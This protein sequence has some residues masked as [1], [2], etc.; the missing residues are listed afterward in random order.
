MFPP[1]GVSWLA[2]VAP[3][4]FYLALPAPS[5]GRAAAFG[6]TVGTGMAAAV[7]APWLWPT[8]R[9]VIAAPAL[10]RAA[11]LLVVLQVVGGL[12]FAALAL[13]A[14]AAGAVAPVARVLLLAAAWTGLEYV[15]AHVPFGTPWA[16]LGAA[17]ADAPLVAQI[18]DLGGVYAV[19]F[20]AALPSA[21]L[22]VAVAVAERGG[23]ARR[24]LVPA[25]AMAALILAAVLAYGRWRLADVT[26]AMRAAPTVRM[27]LVHTDLPSLPHPGPGETRRSLERHLALSPAADPSVD[28]VVWPE[29]AVPALLADD[30]GL[31]DAIRARG[32]AMPYLVGAP[33]IV[34]SGG[35]ATLRASLFL[36]DGDGIRASYDKRELLP[37]VETL[38]STWLPLAPERLGFSPGEGRPVLETNGFTIGPLICYEAIFPERGRAAVR[39]GAAVLLNVSND[40]WLPP[41]ATAQHFLFARLRA[42]EVRRTL[43]RVANRGV[44]AVVDADGRARLV[45]DGTEAGAAIATI[46]RLA[47]LTVYAR[48]GDAFAWLCLAYVVA[49]LSREA[50]RTA[51][52][53]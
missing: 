5:R 46:P 14:H 11:L 7:V 31:L 21:T 32:A 53:R 42:I 51:R 28:L 40:A 9:D 2:W 13:V 19:S 27:A 4:P 25:V 23:N 20:V 22:A 43:V 37:V 3:L 29:N 49:L 52:G 6:W 33:R 24:G 18:A 12:P 44:T 36:V 35:R 41:M 39:A 47:G 50:R 17:L 45:A 38:P 16:F 15:R 10:P 26:I 34:T 48:V 1:W 8:L 30:P